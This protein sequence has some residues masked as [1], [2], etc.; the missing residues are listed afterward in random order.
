GGDGG[1]QREDPDVQLPAEPRDGSPHPRAVG[2]QPP[3]GVGW[4]P[5]SLRRCAAV[6]A[7]A[8]AAGR[9]GRRRPGVRRMTGKAPGPG[10]AEVIRRSTAYLERHGVESPRANVETLLMRLLGVPRPA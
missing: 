9:G 4:R 10:L 5:G 3:R 1:A 2:A 7:A 8:A 6:R